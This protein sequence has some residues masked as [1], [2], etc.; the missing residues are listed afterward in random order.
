MNRVQRPVDQEPGD[1]D[2]DKPNREFVEP[3]IPEDINPLEIPNER[4]Q[5][6]FTKW[7]MERPVEI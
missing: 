2:G 7:L 3:K 6:L 5:Y 1:D 4:D